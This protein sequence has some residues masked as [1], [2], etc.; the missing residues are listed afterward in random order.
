MAMAHERLG[1]IRAARV[2]F[3]RA[4]EHV[5]ALPA[6]AYGEQLRTAINDGLRRLG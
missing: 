1:D 5:V 3:E 4:A 6:D 2:A